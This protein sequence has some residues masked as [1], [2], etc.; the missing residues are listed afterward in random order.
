[1]PALEGDRSRQNQHGSGVQDSISATV[2]IVDAL[3]I[4]FLIIALRC[5]YEDGHAV[6]LDIFK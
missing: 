4:V 6:N 3:M 1:M 5:G 2:N